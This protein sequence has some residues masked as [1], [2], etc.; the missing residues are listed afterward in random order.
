[1]ICCCDRIQFDREEWFIRISNG[2]DWTIG[3]F[4]RQ[5]ITQSTIIDKERFKIQCLVDLKQ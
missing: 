4:E 1:M 5:K 3:W 2:I